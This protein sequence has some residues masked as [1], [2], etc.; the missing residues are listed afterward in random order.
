MGK[1]GRSISKPIT[2]VQVNDIT[3]SGQLRHGSKTTTSILEGG[4]LSSKLFY[5]RYSCSDIL[6]EIKAWVF[7]MYCYHSN[8]SRDHMPPFLIV[9]FQELGR[10]AFCIS[11]KNISGEID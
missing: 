1:I 5:L 4:G 8:M 10:I 9:I 2:S 3:H 6:F 7:Q 11:S